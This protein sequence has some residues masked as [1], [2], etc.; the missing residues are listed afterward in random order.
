VAGI[1][2]LAFGVFDAS[3]TLLLAGGVTTAS[4]AGVRTFY[5]FQQRNEL[6]AKARKA[7]QCAVEA[8]RAGIALGAAG[9]TDG[10][11]TLA[12]TLT[13]AQK[14]ALAQARSQLTANLA[15]VKEPA[16]EAQR[17]AGQVDNNRARVTTTG[18]AT[19]VHATA[20]QATAEV[21]TAADDLQAKMRTIDAKLS[22][23][24]TCT[25]ALAGSGA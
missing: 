6:Y 9:S 17:L 22:N 3:R 7:L 2:T 10:G 23:I 21:V 14:A 11:E 1:A 25:A 18:G 12:Q 24:D 13:Q 20:T 4:V 8:T 19:G 5:P 16:L 15:A